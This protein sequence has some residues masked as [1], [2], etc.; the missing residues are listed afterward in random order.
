[1]LAH[2]ELWM[3]AVDGR[4]HLRAARC[5]ARGGLHGASTR[6]VDPVRAALRV[7]ATAFVL[8]HN[9]PSGDPTP[10]GEDIVLTE[11]VANVA[12]IAQVP[13]LD[14]VIVA[15]DGY[16]SVPLPPSMSC[17]GGLVNHE[18]RTPEG[19]AGQSE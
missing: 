18:A 8:V 9:H 15:R 4:G 17:L 3:L 6:A 12:A 14:H 16:C 11:H 2:E 5:V 1:M 7:D 19:R 13:L 10:S